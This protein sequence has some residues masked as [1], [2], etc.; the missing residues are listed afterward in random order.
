M[1]ED[2]ISNLRLLC[3]YHGSISDVCRA[4]GINRAQF[5][6]YLSGASF[7]S[8]HNLQR[9]IDFFGV[10]DYEIRMPSDQFASIIRLRPLRGLRDE[11][12]PKG[13]ERLAGELRRQQAELSRFHGYFFKYFPSF[14]VAGKVLRS[15]VH[16]GAKE[17][18]TYYKTVE[19]LRS[20]GA[21]AA[22]SPI[23]KYEG[24]V[25]LKGSRLHLIDEEQ[26]VGSEVSQTILYLPNRSRAARLM[27]LMI[28]VSATEAHEPVAARVVLESLGSAVNRRQAL[29]ACGLLDADDPSLDPAI[30]RYVTAEILLTGGLLR[31][32][33]TL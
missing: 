18:I 31:A 1:S 6:K 21:E 20:F 2:F 27:G 11:A 12:M 29:A 5:T 8:R 24:V 4:I 22:G 33:A 23:F 7:P 9:I 28:G 30:G 16:V 17:G 32:P 14:S 15:L 19:R 13:L 26:I 10:E 3:A 25:L